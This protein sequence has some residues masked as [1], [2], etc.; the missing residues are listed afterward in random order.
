MV[1]KKTVFILF[2]FLTS[3]A[4][5]NT[6]KPIPSGDKEV[7]YL[8]HGLGRSKFAMS[9]LAS[10]LEDTGFLVN[11]I[12][13]STINKSPEEILLDVSQ[14]INE[15]LPD[16]DQTVHFVGHSLGG[17]MIRAYLENTKVKNLGRVV[18]IGTPNRGTTL[19]DNYQDTWW[20]K[21]LGPTALS[22]STHKESFPNSIADP[23]Y[24]V[25]V[26]AGIT[27]DKNNEDILPGQDDGLVPLESTK[28][29]G[30]TDFIIIE[31]SHWMMRYNRDVAS[32]TIEFLKLGRFR[33]ET[34]Q[35][36][37]KSEQ[38]KDLK[39]LVHLTML[40]TNSPG[41]LLSINPGLA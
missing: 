4:V 15:S 33:K 27:E 12:G 8:L 19:V 18:L 29:N 21:M 2:V 34:K 16:N 11:N 24:P 41:Y 36:R 7:V 40:K 23:Y 17:L 22:L 20:M 25:G 30:M 31:S 38:N 9:M 5:V 13:Y 35:S 3:C 37:L 28:V 14:Q 10:R 1:L 39:I 26:I 32:Q 6:T